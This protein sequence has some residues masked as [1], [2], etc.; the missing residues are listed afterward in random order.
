MLPQHLLPIE[1]LDAASDALPPPHS[2]AFQPVLL[3]TLGDAVHRSCVLAQAVI[4]SNRR[5]N[6]PQDDPARVCFG[7]NPA[8]EECVAYALV[9][10][11]YP[12]GLTYVGLGPPSTCRVGDGTYRMKPCADRNL[13]D[14]VFG[15]SAF[16]REN[17]DKVR[18]GVSA[19]AFTDTQQTGQDM[20]RRLVPWSVREV[21][22]KLRDMRPTLAANLRDMPMTGV[23][24]VLQQ[25]DRQVC[26]MD[27]RRMLLL[28]F[29]LRGTPLEAMLALP[30]EDVDGDAAQIHLPFQQQP[31]R[32]PGGAAGLYDRMKAFCDLNF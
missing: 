32:V 30:G 24:S 9:T 23:R 2:F 11:V 12:A 14:D 3:T 29:L 19:F 5:L 26:G 27:L 17:T 16:M 13:F 6:Y 8:F 18:C 31:P 28:E 22:A 25:Q 21:A 15:W 4:V 20:V 1:P 10:H 7:R